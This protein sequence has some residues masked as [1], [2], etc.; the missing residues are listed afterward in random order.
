MVGWW[1]HTDHPDDP[2]Y[3]AAP[4]PDAGVFDS[5]LVYIPVNQQ[6]VAHL[7]GLIQRLLAEDAWYGTQDEIDFAIGEVNRLLARL[8]D[9]SLLMDEKIKISP[10]DTTPGYLENKLLAGRHIALTKNNA[11]ANESLTVVSDPASRRAW[12]NFTWLNTAP[13]LVFTLPA[14]AWLSE[15]QVYVDAPFDAPFVASV[16][17]PSANDFFMAG[18]ENDTSVEAAYTKL[19]NYPALGA[20]DVYLYVANSGAS[21]GA[22]RVVLLFED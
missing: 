18:N 10:Q 19:V 5:P 16:G 13:A 4:A 3:Y 17:V 2:R 22:G 1:Q 6:W 9:E 15:V 21:A 12:V 14:G 11:G 20:T 8:T 7:D